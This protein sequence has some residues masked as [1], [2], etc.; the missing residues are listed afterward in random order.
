MAQLELPVLE[1]SASRAQREEQRAGQLYL[2]S[3]P[4]AAKLAQGR[5]YT[6]THLVDFVLD[7][8]GFRS[9][10]AIEKLRLVDPACGG[11]AFL[12]GA[13][14]RLAQRFRARGTRLHTARGA[15]R[16]LRACDRSLFGVD[17]DAEAC[18]L[19]RAAVQ[20]MAATVIHPRGVPAEFFARNVVH[21]DFL[22]DEQVRSLG[23]RAGFDLVVGNPPYVP[24][25]RLSAAEKDRFRELFHTASGRIDLY[26]L[27]FERALELLRGHGR[28]AFITPNKLLTNMS[29]A[30]LR[31]LLRSQASVRMIA[32]FDSH[33]VFPEAATVPCV[34]IV[35][36]AP[37]P[38]R[39]TDYLRCTGAEECVR[40]THESRHDLPDGE[41][42]L[43]EPGVLGLL[44]RLRQKHPP[45]ADFVSRI[46]AGVAT[47][48]DNI[49]VLPTARAD[50]LGLEP[51][52]RHP[53]VR[54]KDVLARGLQPSGLDVIVPYL[55]DAEGVP[56]LV[57]LKSYPRILKYLRLHRAD[58]SERHCVRTW[59]KAWYDLH[60][61]WSFNIAACA[62]ILVPDVAFSNR[63]ASDPGG[64]CP[65]HSAYY[66]VP[67]TDEDLA[68][69]TAVLNSSVVEFCIRATAPVV[70][71]SFIRYR[72]QFLKSLPVPKATAQR[73]AAFLRASDRER[74]AAE[75]FGVSTHDM[76]AMHA[77]VEAARK[78][79]GSKVSGP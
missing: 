61:P 9:D 30:P 60:D 3:L 66:L 24:T 47:G 36:G 25:T 12:S 49:F 18:E 45:L 19:S 2:A 41:W 72:K 50:E 68:Y 5:V 76:E 31:E 56:R 74:A 10:V 54:G 15:E 59:G 13:V 58:L 6:P 67:H 37:S 57:D 33:K 27:F 21:A 22:L 40:V 42:R 77:F 69:L 39:K 48:R 73:R 28:I 52:L 8:A 38:G 75:L 79:H 65:L 7:Q 53:A 62:K 4:R 46:S 55:D 70:K 23:G 63:F 32:E 78:S 26:I 11:G 17:V 29:A 35:D 1:L 43:G 20:A 34:T 51:A 16:F 71:D 44:E 14:V 64:A